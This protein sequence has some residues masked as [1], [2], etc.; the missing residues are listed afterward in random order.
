MN[1]NYEIIHFRE[2]CPEMHE[3]IDF[4]VTFR[5]V[6]ERDRTGYNGR[7]VMV[8]ADYGC[9]YAETRSCV[10]FQRGRECPLFREHRDDL[11]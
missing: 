4:S 3:I 7:D 6:Y 10:I 1:A 8:G 9:I 5:S 11:R 2:F